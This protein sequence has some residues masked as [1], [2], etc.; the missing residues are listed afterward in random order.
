MIMRRHTASQTIAKA[1]GITGLTLLMTLFAAASHS[2]QMYR[3]VDQNGR[4]TYSQNPPPPGAAKN[5]QQRRITGGGGGGDT[6]LPYAAVV[7]SQNFPVTLYTAPD[8]NDACKEGRGMLAK[9]GIPFKEVVAGDEQTV[10]ALRKL[11]G[12]TRVPALLVGRQAL[13]GFEPESWKTA[14]DAAGY[15]ASIPASARRPANVQRNLPAVKLYATAACGQPCQS[16]RELLTVRKIAFQEVLVE[17][18]ESREEL[19]K[20]AGNTDTVPVLL[21]GG[22]SLNGFSP[23][24]YNTALDNAGFQQ[25]AAAKN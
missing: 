3:W 8:C 17:S 13:T 4:V 21:I 11:T 16:A 12:G 7:A 9:R 24:R 1:V 5:V 14:L 18:D 22:S 20:V 23:E 10:E 19:K 25:T 6:N 15:P 2:Q